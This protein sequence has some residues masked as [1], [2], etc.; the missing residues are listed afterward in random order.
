M[1]QQGRSSRAQPVIIMQIKENQR[2][3]FILSHS[4]GTILGVELIHIQFIIGI[5][6]MSAGCAYEPRAECGATSHILRSTNERLWALNYSASIVP[7]CLICSRNFG[8]NLSPADG[9]W[10]LFLL[11]VSYFLYSIGNNITWE[12]RTLTNLSPNKCIVNCTSPTPARVRD[13]V[14]YV[15][16]NFVVW[17]P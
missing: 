10:E 1:A 2:A 13:D 5:H 14:K 9:C 3:K 7:E 17:A 6:Y 4:R 11:F 8:R 15:F 16:F 12:S